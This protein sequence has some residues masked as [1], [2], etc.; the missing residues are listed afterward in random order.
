M[1]YP[2]PVNDYRCVVNADGSILIFERTILGSGDG[3][4]WL[5]RLDLTTPGAE[6]TVFGS[7]LATRPDLVLGLKS[8]RIQ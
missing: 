4:V 2:Q 3:A 8:S 6:P 5:Y 7:A 1:Q